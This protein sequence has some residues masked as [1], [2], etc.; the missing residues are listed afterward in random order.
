[1]IVYDPKKG[2]RKEQDKEQVYFDPKTGELYSS[3]NSSSSEG[4]NSV[5]GIIFGIV[6]LIIVIICAFIWIPDSGWFL[7][8]LKAF[9]WPF[10]LLYYVF[11]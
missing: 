3:S 4:Q 11:G 9:L 8:L 7:G 5:P 2:M 10:V 6:N 1:M